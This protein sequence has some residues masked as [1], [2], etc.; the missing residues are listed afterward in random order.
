MK[1]VPCG[2]EFSHCKF[3]RDAYEAKDKIPLAQI[4]QQSKQNESHSIQVEMSSLEIDNVESHLVKFEDLLKLKKVLENQIPTDELLIENLSSKKL[5]IKHEIRDLQ[6]KEKFYDDN[7]EV[8]EDLEGI[9]K[10]KNLKISA[11]RKC[12]V[13]LE[14]CE[15]ELLKL[16]KLHGF[17]EHRIQNLEVEKTK[18]E[19]LKNDYEAH[20]LYMRCMHPNGIA[21]NI[22]KK[23]L[24]TI[25][26][27]ISK[28]LANVVDFQVL[29]ETDDNR[30]DLYIQ[31]P[32]RDPSPLEMAS[33]AEK[34]VAAMA[35]RL[36]FTNISF[37]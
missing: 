17:S 26:N 24:P 36:A 14:E 20:D 11:F 30:L 29:F 4:G 28:I 5:I 18:C 35:I 10:D 15:S 12:G 7:K 25:N 37:S 1:E 8:I 9:V 19:N 31:Q 6:E 32:D 34:T 2:S 33:G 16:Y 22:I 27:E 13:K 21:Y 23:S 3:I